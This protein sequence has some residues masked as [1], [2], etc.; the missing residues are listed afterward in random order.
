VTVYPASFD[1]SAPATIE[2]AVELLSKHGENAK[3][4]AGGHSL[5]PLMK[6]RFAQ[7]AHVVD[8]RRIPA[9]RGIDR[10]GSMLAIGAMTTYTELATNRD[11]HDLAPALSDAAAHIGDPQV[12]NRGTVGG[13]LAH[14]DPNADLPA[15][16][17]ALNASIDVAG[18]GGRRSIAA[19]E[20]FVDLF[21]TALT[22]GELIIEVRISVP[23]ARVGSGH[24][25][26]AQAASRFALVG[27]AALVEL[28][29][30]SDHVHSARVAVTGLGSTPL[31]AI[32]VEEALI[33][34][35]LDAETI[36]AAA[37]RLMDLP[38]AAERAHTL[39]LARL[40][41]EQAL[42]RAAERAQ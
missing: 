34:R 21:S 14:A 9:L 7:P 35:P 6:L 12:R 24:A 29:R 19:D 17:L 39:Q 13:S 42:Q 18:P 10:D 20:F 5:L 30:L 26:F 37:A 16:M 1:Y 38:D 22:P 8:L 31:R 27:V 32:G 2:E 4:L 23:S 3:L 36:H 11:V 33:A 40:A 28:E 41:T 25:K 15:V